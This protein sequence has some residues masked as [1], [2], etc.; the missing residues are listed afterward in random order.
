MF[1][2][3]GQDL[4]AAS[5]GLLH[6]DL[7]RHHERFL[8]GQGDGLPRLDGREGWDEAH[9][10]HNGGDDLIDLRMRGNVDQPFDP[11]DDFRRLRRKVSS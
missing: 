10:A 1:T 2:V 3:D 4:H 11:V 8:I 5:P 9:G 7:S 6:D